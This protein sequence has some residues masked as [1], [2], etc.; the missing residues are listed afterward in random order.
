MDDRRPPSKRA[1][2]APGVFAGDDE[3]VAA[4]ADYRSAVPV[5]IDAE[6]TPITQATY[7]ALER[8]TDKVDGIALEFAKI[9]GNW[10]GL[11]E[12]VVRSFK[13]Q[14][15]E[16]NANI[17]AARARDEQFHEREWPRLNESIRQVNETLRSIDHRLATTE[18]A[19][20]RLTSAD[21][22]LADR[23]ASQAGVLADLTS[24]LVVLERDKADQLAGDKRE[25]A[26][27]K[28]A[29]ARRAAVLG[30][31]ATAGGAIWQ[32]LQWLVSR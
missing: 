2:S 1:R 8:V 9:Q 22:S 26:L 4:G 17:V 24:R 6:L 14:V 12:P 32:L 3:R 27:T 7:A 28:R 15:D 16:L 25:L 18:R 5:A 31:V 13:A 19:I 29:K 11:V 21:T 10:S 20:E 23:V 30:A